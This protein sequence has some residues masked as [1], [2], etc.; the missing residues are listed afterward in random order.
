MAIKNF[1]K[2]KPFS[3][4]E[5]REWWEYLLA[6]PGLFLACCIF[7]YCFLRDMKI[8]GAIALSV[9]A[10]FS[11]LS[12]ALPKRS[13][14]TNIVWFILTN[15]AIVEIGQIIN[16]TYTISEFNINVLIAGVMFVFAIPM[17]LFIVTGR[18]KISTYI[19]SFLM[20]LLAL[21]NIVVLKFRNFIVF[22]ADIKSIG[23]AAT[24]A[25]GYD[26]DLTQY[27]IIG[28]ALYA[29]LICMSFLF[30]DS[31]F[32]NQVVFR[33]VGCFL[34]GA[35]VAAHIITFEVVNLST[36]FNCG[37]TQNGIYANFY[38]LTVEEVKSNY[39]PS[40]YSESEIA[41]LEAKYPG[42]TNEEFQN[43]LADDN[44][45]TVIVI[46]NESFA[47]FRILGDNFKT[48]ESVTP[49]IDSL[50][51]NTIRGYALASQIGAGTSVSEYEFLS[52]NNN[53]FI[54]AGVT[55]ICLCYANLHMLCHR[56]S[57]VL[58]I[59]RMPL[60]LCLL[61]IGLV[62]LRGGI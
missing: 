32:K 60:T 10:L 29:L 2:Q 46:M 57:S 21:A 50:Y 30:G 1:F 37:P 24:V 61:I 26:F 4:I 17:L 18:I 51:E 40:G 38:Y 52:G 22:P 42:Y 27:Q 25:K 19:G 36:W 34:L 53:T 54:A 3:G 16:E 13:K 9:F 15:G 11:I 59:E 48:N 49:F 47:D 12:Y 43:V 35:L 33:V 39:P 41:L 8:V 20:V 23:T 14:I 58:D 44:K 45:P 55:L 56:C 28:L 5:D 62:V 31:K 7:N 6:L